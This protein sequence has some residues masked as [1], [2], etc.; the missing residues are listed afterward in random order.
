MNMCRNNTHSF[1]EIQENFLF[2]EPSIAKNV[3]YICTSIVIA[4]I[5][6]CIYTCMDTVP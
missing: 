6:T 2:L 4:C 1:L 3:N 5:T